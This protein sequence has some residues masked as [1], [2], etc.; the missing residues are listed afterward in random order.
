MLKYPHL[1]AITVLY[2]CCCY[3]FIYNYILSKVICKLREQ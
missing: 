3:Y 2:K 1:K